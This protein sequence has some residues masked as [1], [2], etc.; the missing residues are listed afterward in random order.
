MSI[1]NT[2]RMGKFSSDRSIKEYCQKVWDVQ[3]CPVK[4]KWK[5]LPEDGVLFHPEETQEE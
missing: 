5:E 2:A 4:L 1:L 3:P